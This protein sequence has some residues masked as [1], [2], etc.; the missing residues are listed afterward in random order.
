M[1][2]ADYAKI[3]ILGLLI[4]GVVYLT[5]FSPY[6]DDFSRE[7]LRALVE[8]AG[9][10]GPLV[11]FAAFVLGTLF[12]M[13]GIVFIGLGAILW[14]TTKGFIINYACHVLGGIITFYIIRWFGRGVIA[15]SE[16][17]LVKHYNEKMKKH[18]FI[19]ILYLRLMFVPLGPANY[20]AALSPMTFWEFFWSLV[21]GTL[22]STFVLTFFVD[23]LT[24]IS[25][26]SDLLSVP[27]FLAILLTAASLSVPFIFKRL[28]QRIK[29][30]FYIPD[31]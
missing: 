16:M 19:T 2:R 8:H 14:G 28:P 10:W 15:N 26:I 27:M 4:L 24:S 22:P 6:A 11:F 23:Q 25:S 12:F 7:A 13:A 17:K 30:R 21:I 18:G 29:R 3:G 9:I 5:R 31:E 20:A 1:R